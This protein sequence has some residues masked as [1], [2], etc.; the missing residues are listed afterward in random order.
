M[1]FPREIMPLKKLHLDTENA[2]HG[3]LDVEDEAIK[4][5]LTDYRAREKTYR[6]AKAIAERGLSPID[7]ILVVPMDDTASDYIVAEGNRRVTALKL[8]QNPD[9][10]PTDTMRRRYEQL[11]SGARVSISNAIECKVAPGFQE[12][13][14][15]VQLRHGG[16]QEGIGTVPWGSKELE[17]FNARIGRRG[18]N[19]KSMDVLDYAY[20]NKLLS[21]D[22]IRNFP[23]TNLSRLLKDPAV[24]AR[25]GLEVTAD[26]I[27]STLQ[28]SSFQKALGTLLCQLADGEITVTNIKQKNQ[29]REYVEKVM[30]E[31]GVTIDKKAS[32]PYE[33][34]GSKPYYNNGS[35]TPQP[36]GRGRRPSHERKTMIPRNTK[37]GFTLKRLNDVFGELQDI[38]VEDYPNAAAVL[39]RV[40]FEGCLDRYAEKAKVTGYNRNSD[41]LKKR[42]QLVIDHLKQTGR[43]DKRVA[44]PVGA[45]LTS[46]NN[47]A[48]I[49]T[50]NSYIHNIKHQPIPSDLK[51]TWDNLASFFEALDGH[52]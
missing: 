28:G 52:L 46:P 21:G 4:W 22:Q 38:S 3:K 5:M 50:F 40:F 6:L 48:S 37:L 9:L 19:A 49:E 27:R 18:P 1:E 34:K 44:G 24:R 39:F 14:Y 47:V 8:L 11:V 30:T 36:R 15:W 29:R 16:E 45:F 13:S 32:Q 2:R 17:R 23:L 7:D 42:A 31:S 12:A 33:L 43:I 25:M 10:A 20:E 41:N 26:G 51:T 35:T